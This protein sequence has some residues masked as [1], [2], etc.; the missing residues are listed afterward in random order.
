MAGE[1]DV[2]QGLEGVYVFVNPIK[3]E[4]EKYSL[5]EKDLQRDTELQ[6]MQYGIKVLTHEEW[7]STPEMLCLWIEVVLLTA[8]ESTVAAASIVVELHENVLLLREPKKVCIIAATWHRGNVWSGGVHSINK[9]RGHVKDLVSEFTKDYLA[10]NPKE[11]KAK[12][13]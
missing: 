13:K 3:P 4:A 2:L 1:K 8:E 7:L 6:L 9:I 12:S 10:A 5:T 11:T